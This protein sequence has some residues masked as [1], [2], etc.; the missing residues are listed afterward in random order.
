MKK[1]LLYFLY[2]FIVT[3]AILEI[4]IRLLTSTNPANV[5][6]FLDKKHH[7]LLP[8]PND[9]ASFHKAGIMSSKRDG[10]RVFD[11]ELG[12][13]HAHW[14]MDTSDYP[15]FSNDLGMRISE[16]QFLERDS[17]KKKYKILAIG[18]SFTHGDAVRAEDTWVYMLEQK[19]NQPVGNLGV[20]GFG[21]QQVLLRLMNSKIEADT[22][23]F[24]VI[25]GDLERAM[26][27]VYT[28]YQGGNKTRPVLSFNDENSFNWVNKPVM[29]P[30]DFYQSKKEHRDEIYQHIIG[31]DERVFSDAL[32]TKSYLLRLILSTA[33]QKKYFDVKPI[34]IA[35]DHRLEYCMKIFQLFN[36]YCRANKM[37]GK[38][39]LL[40]TGQNFWHKD[41]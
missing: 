35:D 30:T 26:E 6:L 13:S 34:Y 18:N 33:H 19:L 32:W 37:Y 40:D 41:K 17:A 22:V 28:F 9:S 11:K 21:I 1:K 23:L 14:G 8:L 29:T 20:G 24:G 7:Y 16:R 39:V 12:W 2:L 5:E 15:C 4:A 31:F 25:W 27:P 3:F 38:V 36:D 10:Y